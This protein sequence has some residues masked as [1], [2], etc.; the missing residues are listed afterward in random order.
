MKWAPCPLP[1]AK[2]VAVDSS[3]AA[4]ASVSRVMGF[5]YIPILIYNDTAGLSG[6]VARISGNSR[7][8]IFSTASRCGC[9]HLVPCGKGVGGIHQGRAAAH[10]DAHRHDRAEVF[11]GG[12]GADQGLD[13]EIHARL[14]TLGD[15]DGQRHIFTLF[16]RERAFFFGGSV[17]A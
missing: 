5:P 13:V 9:G 12:S 17:S 10:L 6:S 4:V 2:A 14:A 8:G 1:W 16:H 11:A 7:D 3:R 15:G